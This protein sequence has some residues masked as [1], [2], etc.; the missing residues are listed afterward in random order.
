MSINAKG[1][2][3]SERFDKVHMPDRFVA[4]DIVLHYPTLIGDTNERCLKKY[5]QMT[6]EEAI[7]MAKLLDAS[8]TY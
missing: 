7:A 2:S 6:K 4:V 8:Q 3:I 1:W 5:G